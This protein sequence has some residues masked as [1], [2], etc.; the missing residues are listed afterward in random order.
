MIA[1]WGGIKGYPVVMS[2]FAAGNTKYVGDDGKIINTSGALTHPWYGQDKLR[3]GYFCSKK[4]RDYHLT[5]A[6]PDKNGNS[7]LFGDQNQILLR[8]AEILLDRAEC[9]VRTGDIAGAMEDLKLVRDRAWGGLAP[10]VMQ[11]GMNYDGSP[12][13][14]ITDPLQ[15]VL[16]EYRHELTGEYSLFYNLRRAGADVAVNF[17]TSNYGSGNL[18][19][20]PNPGPGPTNDGQIHGMY[21]A[22]MTVSHELLPIPSLSIAL[23]PN[24]TQ[25]PGY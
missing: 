21:N 7:A 16:S 4:W 9:K 15:M 19:P 2:S 23:N 3:T 13:T 12:S 18:L 6:N 14:P 25:N 8:Y 20:I 22:P 17:I 11:D 24:L 1:Y 10:A 5:G